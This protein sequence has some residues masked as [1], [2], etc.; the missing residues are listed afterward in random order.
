MEADRNSHTIYGEGGAVVVESYR[1]DPLWLRSLRLANEWA[2][3]LLTLI[4]FILILFQ[5][6]FRYVMNDSLIWSEEFVRFTL[7]YV[8]VLGLGPVA[9]RSAHMCMDGLEKL[10]PPSIGYWITFAANLVSLAF[11]LL[12][13]W[14]G[15]DFVFKSQLTLAPAM[16]IS[17]AYVYA[18]I[19]VGAALGI[20]FTI[21]SMTRGARS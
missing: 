9:D 18:A 19:P 21:V 10:V 5:I 16:G 4:F 15:V 6:F 3:G 14:F 7:F 13:I 20:I 1:G 17:M 2:I 12:L 11:Q 8:V